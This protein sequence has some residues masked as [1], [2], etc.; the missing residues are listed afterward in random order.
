MRFVELDE[1]D[2]SDREGEFA[3]IAAGCDAYLP[4]DEEEWVVDSAVNC[5][6]CRRR[7]WVAGGFQCMKE[8]S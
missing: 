8:E 5:M 1:Q 3:R 2:Y 6:N 7:R 4:D